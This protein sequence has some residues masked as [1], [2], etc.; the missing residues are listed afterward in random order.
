LVASNV[1]DIWL[2]KPLVTED[3]GLGKCGGGIQGL[4]LWSMYPARDGKIARTVAVR[5]GTASAREGQS[6][7]L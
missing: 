4:P 3:K 5:G 6:K 7:S 1:R 2:V